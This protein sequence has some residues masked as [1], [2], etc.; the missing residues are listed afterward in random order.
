MML[1]GND[2]EVVVVVIIITAQ[3]STAFMRSTID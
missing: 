3:H 2:M 1:Q